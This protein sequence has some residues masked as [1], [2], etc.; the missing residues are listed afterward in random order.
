[1]ERQRRGR[2][3]WGFGRQRKGLMRSESG[4]N[5]SRKAGTFVSALH[6][7]REWWVGTYN[8][9]HLVAIPCNGVGELDTG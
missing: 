1:M 8:V 6:M 3:R 4:K 2:L 7:R 9:Q 5:R